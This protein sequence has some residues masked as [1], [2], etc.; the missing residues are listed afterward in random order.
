MTGEASWKELFLAVIC[1]VPIIGLWVFINRKDTKLPSQQEV[2]L[3]ACEAL[4]AKHSDVDITGI[5]PLFSTRQEGMTHYGHAVIRVIWRQDEWG[6]RAECA[7]FREIG[8]QT[9]SFL[10]LVVNGETLSHEVRRKQ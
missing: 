1:V 10:D 8:T 2:V 3:A 9:F 5:K 6:V 4:L 7:G